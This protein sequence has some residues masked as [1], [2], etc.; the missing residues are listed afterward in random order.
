MKKSFRVLGGAAVLLLA[1][2]ALAGCPDPN[3]VP[4]GTVSTLAGS[5]SGYEDGTGAA[6]KFKN[7]SGVAVDGSGNVYVADTENHRIRK[8]TSEGVVSVLAGSGTAGSADGTGA[9][10]AFKS[11]SGV[12]VDSSGNVYVADT[13]NHRIRKITS[14]GV[15]SVFAGSGTAGATD[16][17]GASAT[18][19]SPSGVAVD[20]SGNVYVAD[21]GNHLI[22]KITSGGVVSVFAGST[23]AGYTDATGTA[24]AF[25]SPSGV[26][27]DGSGNVY[28]ADTGNN[29][30]RHITSGGV[31]T[32]LAGSG[33][34][35][36]T[37][38]TG[39]AAA[40]YKPFGIAVDSSGNVYVADTG[41][42]VADTYGRI[43]K[44]TPAGVVST[45]GKSDTF[46]NP[47]GV[48]VDSSG[49][50]YVADTYNDR[51]RKI[52]SEGVVTTLAGSTQGYADGTG[53]AAQYYNPRGGVAVDSSGNVYVA[54][55][56]NNRIRKITPEGL[57]GTIAGSLYNTPGYAEGIGA[58]A[59]FKSPYGVAV[60]DSGNVYVADTSN[61]RIRK[62]IF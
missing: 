51:I 53:V 15:V 4:P 26:A 10:A 60:D 25:K 48:A 38:G 14:E 35:S 61:H 13:E 11:P 23:T 3:L 50:V 2:I 27:V 37:D 22:R 47:Y 54:D 57:V 32:T 59:Q 43:R 62:I 20:G 40:F 45:L 42:V 34:V 49:N 58:A 36:S 56:G 5:T 39:T 19:K 21:T 12:A 17:T 31:V 18:F 8:I 9:S 44:I 28:V 1:A 7:P 52:T 16:G 30:I 33:A 46:K 55:T 41:D 29:R 24:A 6:A